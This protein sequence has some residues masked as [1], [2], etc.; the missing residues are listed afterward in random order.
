MVQ[1]VNEFKKCGGNTGPVVNY[2]WCHK[3]F[4][5]RPVLF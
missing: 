3:I 2:L 5:A 4:S 1:I